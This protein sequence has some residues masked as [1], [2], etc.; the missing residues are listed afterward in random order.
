MTGF[1]VGGNDRSAE[2]DV[3]SRYIE[4]RGTAGK[5]GFHHTVDAH[6][7]DFGVTLVLSPK[8]LLVASMTGAMEQGD[9]SK[10][11]RHIPMFAPEVAARIGEGAPIADVNRARLPVRPLEQL[12]LERPDY[13]P[14]RGTGPPPFPTT[15]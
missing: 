10:P 8:T 15:S 4:L 7:I 14:E 2:A 1:R 13:D 11:Y 3:T 6:S 12:P 9:P 5:R